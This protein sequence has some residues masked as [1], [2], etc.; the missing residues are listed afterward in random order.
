[1]DNAPK[2][3]SE[4]AYNLLRYAVGRDHLSNYTRFAAEQLTKNGAMTVP[5]LVKAMEDRGYKSG[6]A[7]SQAQQMSKLFRTFGMSSKDGKTMV[8]DDTSPLVKAVRTRLNL[9]A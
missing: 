4:K 6:T 5:E 1:M 3:V 8:L 7:R 9:A 2:K